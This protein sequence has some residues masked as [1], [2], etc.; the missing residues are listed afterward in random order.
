VPTS[1]SIVSE[2]RGGCAILLVTGEV[3]MSTAPR[4]SEAVERAADPGMPLVADLTGVEFL[5]S[6]GARALAAADRE[7]EA[8]GGRLL[9]VPS[10]AVNRVVDL[11]GLE[12]GLHL[13]TTLDEALE[14]GRRFLSFRR[15]QG[16]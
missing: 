12:S 7:L 13:H 15:Q 16:D 2:Y 11:G 10:A 3:D 4:L 8:D 6:A 14:A 9:T 5:D 1:L